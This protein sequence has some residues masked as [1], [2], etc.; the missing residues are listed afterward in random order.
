M[1]QGPRKPYQYSGE[2]PEPSTANTGFLF[3]LIVL[4]LEKFLTNTKQKM[5]YT[6]VLIQTNHKHGVI[7]P[8]W[9]TETSKHLL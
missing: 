2:L 1:A 8:E 5:G 4:E 7:R 6:T 3:Q 9:F